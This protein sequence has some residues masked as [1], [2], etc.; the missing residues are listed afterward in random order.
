MP[1]VEIRPYGED[2]RAVAESLFR[3]AG[4]GAPTE[5]LWG[6]VESE[7][8]I[9]LAPYLDIEPESTFPRLRRR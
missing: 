8:A 3:A 1:D 2:D 5:S 7:A 6:H 9:Y 4:E